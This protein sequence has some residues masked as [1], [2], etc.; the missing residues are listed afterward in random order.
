MFFE[1]LGQ[2]MIS[3]FR[4]GW[5]ELAT[6]SR[7]FLT[8]EKWYFLGRGHFSR[9]K[10]GIS[11]V[12]EPQKSNVDTFSTPLTGGEIAVSCEL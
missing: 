7:A 3:T 8:A 9:L 6:Q 12:A 4:G 11:S 5:N 10:N 2:V 1:N